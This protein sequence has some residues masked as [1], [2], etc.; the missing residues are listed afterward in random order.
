VISQGGF[1][2]FWSRPLSRVCL[3]LTVAVIVLPLIS[4]F[5]LKRSLRLRPASE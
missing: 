3:T 1:N 5:R 2:I 4:N